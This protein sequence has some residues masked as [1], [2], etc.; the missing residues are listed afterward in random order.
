[1][2]KTRVA[3]IGGERFQLLLIAVLALVPFA[4]LAVWARLGSQAVW[5]Q[6]LLAA[7]L[8]PS[9]VL[10]TISETVNTA[11]NLPLWALVIVVAAVAMFV[12]R[13][14]RAAALVLLT[15]LS[16]LAA[17]LV[18]VIVERARPD[19]AAV[20]QFFGADN[21]SFPS[22]HTV[23][24]AALIAV[25]I[26]LMAPSRTRVPLALLG[27]L[28]SGLVMGYARVSLGVHW[29]TDTIGGT[30]LGLAWF[31]LTTVLVWRVAKPPPE[32]DRP[33]G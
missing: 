3:P 21:F 9:G 25:V 7:L 33:Q 8:A 2:A 29:P 16:D 14:L 26:W 20:E 11:G 28:I 1:V 5:E 17:F 19:T 15:F 23:R 18:K 24:A 4:L 30:L 12:L 27:G 32:L 10:G 31:A 22:G 13:G 6:G